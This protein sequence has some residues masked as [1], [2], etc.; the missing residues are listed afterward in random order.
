MN[1][2]AVDLG[3]TRLKAARMTH[4]ESVPADI[5]TLEH[6][7]DWRG[8]LGAVIDH[9]DDVAELA[10]CV[11]GLVDR[12]R[13]IALPG[14]LPGLEGAD[15]GAEL[16]MPVLLVNDAVAYAVGEGV[17][18][19]GR[20][21][22]RVVVITIG[23]G[24]GVG[25]VE[26]SAPLGEGPLGGGI[27]GGQ[28]PLAAGHPNP[29][30]AERGAP[31]TPAL[32]PTDTSGRE[33]TFEARCRASS[34]LARVPAAK[35]LPAAYALLRSGDKGA[36]RGFAEYREWL[37]RGLTVLAM[38][39][40]P[41]AMVVGGGA[42][43]PGLLDGVEDALAETLWSGQEVAVRLAELGDAAALA[44]LGV[45]WRRAEA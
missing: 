29:A 18:G 44:G 42:A 41:S 25:V 23:T 33:G 22:H 24:V 31:P 39:H 5:F 38:A 8:G 7:G 3:G 40:A 16:G 45:L 2:L 10:L 4:G 43:Q 1:F 17:H 19:A 35:D 12:G 28:I 14:K 13:V 26:D 30:A 37:A 27:L 20:D 34:L 9:F 21:H 15:V 36:A 11:P 32:A 6:D